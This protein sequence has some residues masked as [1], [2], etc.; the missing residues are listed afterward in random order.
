MMAKWRIVW[1]DPNREC[2]EVVDDDAAV[3]ASIQRLHS[4]G[5]S[6]RPIVEVLRLPNGYPS[7]G[8]ATGGLESVVTFQATNDPPYFISVGDVNRVGD[9]D[10]LCHGKQVIEHLARNLVAWENALTALQQ[11][12]TTCERPKTLKWEAL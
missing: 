9:T 1:S 2:T 11:F 3:L 12:L 5:V 7:I 4:S 10:A 6:P 8:L